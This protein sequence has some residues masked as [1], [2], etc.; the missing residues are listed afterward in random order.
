MT[1]TRTRTAG[2]TLL[3]ALVFA[4]ACGS[5]HRD[6]GAPESGS[7][8]STPPATEAPAPSVPA[9]AWTVAVAPRH[10]TTGSTSWTVDD[11]TVTAQGQTTGAASAIESALD[12]E[13]DREAQAA[14]ADP[15]APLGFELHR[16]RVEFLGDRYMTVVLVS[17]TDHGGAHPVPSTASVTFDLR[18]GAKFPAL[19]LFTS[20]EAGLLALRDAIRPRL[21]AWQAA[22]TEWVSRGTEISLD[23]YRTLAP[24]SDGMLVRFDDYQVG[25]HSIGLVDVVVPWAALDPALK[26][27][28]VPQAERTPAHYGTGGLLPTAA[29]A[30]PPAP[31]ALKSAG[32]P[33]VIQMKLG[34][35]DYQWMFVTLADTGDVVVLHDDVNNPG[36][37][38]AARGPWPLPCNAVPA[39]LLV[40]QGEAC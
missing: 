5:D 12:A 22:S 33:L 16:D 7:A 9:S 6:V 21:V 36:W 3:A 26:P 10:G 27:D 28:A 37:V 11:F 20:P 35:T 30:Y 32:D 4:G 8:R 15:S 1:R 34:P 40:V 23:N 2:L 39:R 18:T 38:E 29:D 17:S 31:N 14:A 25:P 19:D 24:R 13:A